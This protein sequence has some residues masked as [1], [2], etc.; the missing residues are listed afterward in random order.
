MNNNN[1]ARKQ[2]N[3]AGKAG[4]SIKTVNKEVNGIIGKE[5]TITTPKRKK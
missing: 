4:T 5:E 3:E 2:P 1:V